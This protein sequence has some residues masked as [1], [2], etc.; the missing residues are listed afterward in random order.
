MN[1]STIYLIYNKYIYKFAYILHLSTHRIQVNISA[2]C[3]HIQYE[4]IVNQIHGKPNA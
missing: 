1:I 3:T 2:K 4:T